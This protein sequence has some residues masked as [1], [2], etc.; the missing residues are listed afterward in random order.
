MLGCCCVCFGV[1]VFVMRLRL[2]WCCRVYDE[3]AV[4]FGGMRG[5]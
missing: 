1:A 5:G 2:F 3:A 4:V